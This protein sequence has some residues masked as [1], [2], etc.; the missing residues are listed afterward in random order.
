M[1]LS[2][3]QHDPTALL[4]LLADALALLAMDIL[5]VHFRQYV[6]KGR[7]DF[8]LCCVTV[9]LDTPIL[10]P[11]NRINLS[12]FSGLKVIICLTTLPPHLLLDIVLTFLRILYT[13]CCDDF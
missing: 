3:I 8:I 2:Y 1:L 12:P 9:V 10:S 13:L 6:P 4:I 5:L 7:I 11:I